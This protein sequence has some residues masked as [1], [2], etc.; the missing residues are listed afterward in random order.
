MSSEK[1]VFTKDD[2]DTYL[3]ELAKE[4]RRVSGKSVP[5]ELILIGGASVLINYGFRDMTTDVDALLLAASTMKEAINRV[6]DKFGLPDRWL[7][8]DFKRTA[9]YTPRLAEF[10]T[11]YKRYY[12]VLEVR[13]VSAQ[14]LIAMKLRSGRPYK[15]D[16]SDVLGILAEHE[17]KGIPLTIEDIRKAVIDLYGAWDTLPPASAAF[18]ESAMSAGDFSAQYAR[19]AASEQAAKSALVEFEQAYPGVTNAGNVGEILN[20]LKK[21]NS[22][23]TEKR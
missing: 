18:M 2:L 3:K 15:N 13:T 20:I 21:R 10:T 12:G 22:D 16:L 23:D 4:Y 1:I 19:I 11:F 5:A 14:H 7:N 17:Q 8:E 9:S 6:G